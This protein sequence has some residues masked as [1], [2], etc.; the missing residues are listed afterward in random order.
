MFSCNYGNG[1]GHGLSADNF[2]RCT[3]LFAARRLVL[4]DWIN[5]ADEYMKPNT[6]H[7]KWQEFENDSIIYSLFES[8][9]NQ[10]SLRQVDYKGK[11][12]NIKNEFFFMSKQEILGLSEE[13]SNDD[14]YNDARVS[15][16][17]Y[18]YELLEGIELSEEAQAVL[19]KAR[20]IVRKTFKYRKLFN[21]EH[22]EYQVMNWDASYYQMKPL[23]KEYAKE[24]FEQFKELYKK[25]ADKML[26]M[27]YEL[28]FL[29]K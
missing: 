21:E 10:S 12:W 26:P 3:S 18:V 16:E 19:D 7:E 28:G 24:D 6:D 5:W 13:F 8:K 2:T 20:E 11:K 29:R 14:C 22:P 9:S 17:R 1:H 23:W 27:V 4:S 15:K 25:L